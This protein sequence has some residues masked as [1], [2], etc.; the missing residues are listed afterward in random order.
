M[1]LSETKYCVVLP[2]HLL[3]DIIF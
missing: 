1:N 3:H 2:H